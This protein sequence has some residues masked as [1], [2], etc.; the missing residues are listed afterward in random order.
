L[1]DNLYLFYGDESLTINE[2]IKALKQPGRGLENIDGSKVD[3]ELVLNALQT[4]S[5]FAEQKLVL[6]KGL[7]L[8][9]PLWDEV[10]LA[11][12]NIAQGIVVV[13]WPEAMNKRSKLYKAVDKLGQIYECKGF[14]AWEQD[15]VVAWIIKRVK[16]EGKAIEGE[17]AL[18]LQEVC[19]SSL[20]NLSSEIEKL[21]TYI[22]QQATIKV[23]DI[24]LLAS[25]GQINV[26][27]LAEAVANRDLILALTTFRILSKN[28]SEIFPILSLLANQFRTMLLTKQTS[29]LAS[30]GLSPFYVKKCARAAGKYQEAELKKNLELILETD[31]K[32]KSGENQ[33]TNFELLLAEMCG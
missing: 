32:L 13:F 3:L 19:G 25:P 15:K 28:K 6:I 21:V 23:A 30:F 22:G 24:E 10:A 11:L 18:T 14:A 12:V 31:L 29:N 5:L 20:Q 7:N 4:H 27:A 33:Q 8:K 9:D 16:A 2:R 1:A 17:A 26:F